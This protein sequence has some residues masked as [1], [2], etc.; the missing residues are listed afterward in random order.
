MIAP[1]RSWI[2]RYGVVAAL[3]A[4]SVIA[5]IVAPGFFSLDNASTILLHVSINSILTLGMTLAISTAG[6]D[7]SV[8]S[9]LGL[10][11]VLVAGAQTAPGL[12]AVVGVGGAAVV[13]TLSGLAVVAAVGIAN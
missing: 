3:I 12:I 1:N 4:M 11:D 8:G 7:L 2:T 5:T 10:A 13:A 9:L 6:M